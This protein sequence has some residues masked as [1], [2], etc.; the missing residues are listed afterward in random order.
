MVGH[1]GSHGRSRFDRLVNPAEV[2]VHE[3]QR[4]GVAVIFNLFAEGVRQPRESADAHSHRQVLA[5]DQ[6]G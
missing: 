5:F 2:V 3:M 1:F 6:A 4:D